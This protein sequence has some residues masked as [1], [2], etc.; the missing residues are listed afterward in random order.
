[1]PIA[2]LGLMLG[3]AIALQID[4]NRPDPVCNVSAT[5]L[6]KMYDEIMA[7]QFKIADSLQGKK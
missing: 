2:L 6:N 5:E 3:W 4:L 1:M 7:N